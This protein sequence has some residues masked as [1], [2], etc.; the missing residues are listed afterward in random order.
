MVDSDGQLDGYRE[1]RQR[2]VQV[3]AS[4]RLLWCYVGNWKKRVFL[5]WESVCEPGFLETQER[6]RSGL[7]CFYF[8]FCIDL[9]LQIRSLSIQWE[10]TVSWWTFGEWQVEAEEHGLVFCWDW[11]SGSHWLPGSFY[12]RRPS[13]RKLDKNEKQTQPGVGWTGVSV[14]NTPEYNGHRKITV[15]QRPRNLARGPMISYSLVSWLPRNTWTAGPW[16]H[17]GKWCVGEECCFSPSVT[18]SAF[19]LSGS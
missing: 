11:L 18:H 14:R 3:A 15:H 12:P 7:G 4:R 2:T 9:L 6:Y 16:R 8:Y 1:Q 19:C 13:W 17:I 5:P 10:Y